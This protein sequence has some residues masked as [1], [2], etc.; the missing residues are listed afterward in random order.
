EQYFQ[1]RR[2]FRILIVE[3]NPDWRARLRTVLQRLAPCELSEAGTYEE[4]IE[5]ARAYRP[6]LISLD[7]EIP[8][9]GMSQPE[10]GID[11][12][13]QLT[14]ELGGEETGPS[15]LVLTAHDVPWLR[16]ELVRLVPG[17]DIPGTAGRLQ[18]LD[19]LRRRVDARAICLK[20]E[21]E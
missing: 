16:Q 13:R 6:N 21:G 1:Q 18:V 11:L 7:L 20:Q 19:L 17:P 4:A 10:N 5:Q 12:R 9:D 8:R 2:P 15:F 3:D 14:R